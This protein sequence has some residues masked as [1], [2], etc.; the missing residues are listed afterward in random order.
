MSYRD[1]EE[2]IL[3]YLRE[4]KTASIQELC[5]ELFVSEPTMRRDLAILNKQGKIV[6]TYGAAAIR[7]EL[8][9]NLPQTYR[10]REHSEEKILIAKKCLELI[11]DGDTVMVDASSTADALLQL[12][13]SKASIVLITNNAKAPVT[14]FESSIKTFVTGGELSPSTYAYVGSYAE[15]F[16]RAFNADICFFSIR[17]LTPDGLL[18]DNAVSENAIRKVMLARSKKKV[19]MMDSKKIGSPC[20][21]TLCTTEDIDL[22]VSEKDISALC[23][24]APSVLRER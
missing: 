4:R 3:A 22:V 10:E 1:R 9:E 14:L 11:H 6:R 24:S 16:L 21:N 19:L 13:G 8:C 5:R 12:L 2:H 18:T 7:S 15:N 17:R 20:I 23:P